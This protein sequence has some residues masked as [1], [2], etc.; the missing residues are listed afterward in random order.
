MRSVN[1]IIYRY[2]TNADFFNINKPRLSEASG[3]GQSYIDFPVNDI[4]VAKWRDFFKGAAGVKETQAAKGPAW[5]FPVFSVGVSGTNEQDLKIYQRRTST[6]SVAAQKIHSQQSNR[7]KAWHPT[8]GFPAPTDP[9]DRH[10]LP[11]GLVVYLV[12]TAEN[13]IWAGWFVRNSTSF[14]GSTDA[15]VLKYLADM[16]SANRGE[17]DAGILF[18]TNNQIT[19]D[20]N[21]PNVTF[22][23]GGS[24]T[25]TVKAS[26]NKPKFSKKSITKKKVAKK[27]TTKNVFKQPVRTE[28]QINE[29]LFSEDSDYANSEDQAVI[30]RVS[31]IKKRNQRAVHDL[32]ELYEFKCQVSDTKYLFKKKNG[33]FYTEAH[34]LIP[35]GEGGSDSPLNMVVLSPLIHRMFHYADVGNLDLSKIKPNP[36]GSASLV[37]AINGKGY[38]ITYKKSHYER[39]KKYEESNS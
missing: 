11:T 25:G 38:T 21:N 39:I 9:I 3:G 34:H 31:I 19:L 30:E 2:L 16:Y 37:V 13:D 29:S 28:E 32:K 15:N 10:Q 27:K 22:I 36:D 8:F 1:S 4:S 24:L 35:L 33:V 12:R 14:P 23:A 20:A 26:S 7:V 5:N 18:C 17:G 6:V